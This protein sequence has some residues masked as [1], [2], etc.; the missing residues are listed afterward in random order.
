[1]RATKTP[2]KSHSI[3]S[4]TLVASS[5]GLGTHSLHRLPS[6]RA[7][8]QLLEAAFDCGVSYFD[9]APS[10]GDGIAEEE[11]GR[12]VNGRRSGLVLTTKFGF[13]THRLGARVP[14]WNYIASAGRLSRRL[15][16][17]GSRKLPPQDFS[18]AHVADSVDAS[19]RAL[20]TDCIDILYLHEP[21][22]AAVPDPEGLAVALGSLKAAGKVRYVGF[23]GRAA[24]CVELAEHH[25][26]L[27]QV[28]QLEV[29][30]AADGLPEAASSDLATAAVT[31]WE[32]PAG[33]VPVD[34]LRGALERMLAASPGRIMMLSTNS[35]ASVRETV[36]ILENFAKDPQL[37]ATS[38]LA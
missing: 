27:A 37:S 31:F 29:P 8:Q 9:T 34:T 23:A 22:L 21:S 2:I 4:T 15:I 13:P 30:R 18:P 6:S 24:T 16:S 3:Q 5:L 19:L 33:P 14:G 32:L 36:A 26:S 35:V 1:L 28:L 25:Q 12:F 10:Y 38:S 11:L 20:R 7:R 17:R